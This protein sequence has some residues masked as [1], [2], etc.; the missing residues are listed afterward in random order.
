MKKLILISFALISISAFSQQT[1][2]LN[3]GGSL[4]QIDSNA[5]ITNIAQDNVVTNVVTKSGTEFKYAL[6][7]TSP[8]FTSLTVDTIQAGIPLSQWHQTA[9][10]NTTNTNWNDFKFNLRTHHTFYI[11]TTD[12]VNFTV[13][14]SGY[15]TVRLCARP[16]YSSAASRTIL[17]RG[18]DN[19]VEQ[20]CLQ[21][22]ETKTSGINDNSTISF[23][24]KVYLAAGQLLKVQY[25]V[26]N[27]DVDFQ[28]NA[29]FDY[30]VSAT[31]TID[32]S[33]R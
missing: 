26:S 28:G 2:N 25:K 9:L 18:L 11:T 6:T 15:Y 30:P 17:L 12:S 4:S 10:I 5:V 20:R 33:S 19:N 16:L 23:E 32:Y 8:Q 14:K 21:Y 27:A 1:I 29:G 31:L 22:S 3:G 13:T 24:G 7:T